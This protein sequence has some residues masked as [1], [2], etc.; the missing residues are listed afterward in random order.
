MALVEHG[1]I[2]A[3]GISLFVTYGVVPTF[4]GW[5]GIVVMT[6]ADSTHRYCRSS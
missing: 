6:V 4:I 3:L 1:A 2:I 5:T